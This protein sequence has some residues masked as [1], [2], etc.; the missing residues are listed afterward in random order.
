[1]EGILIT[2]VEETLFLQLALIWKTPK[3]RTYTS[4]YDDGI[5]W[6]LIDEGYLPKLGEKYPMSIGVCQ[7]NHPKWA[8]GQFP[9]G[10]D[11]IGIGFM[12]IL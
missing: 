5:N 6:E 4:R 12:G 2:R 7:T 3:W 11:K 9:Y 8:V 10:K 1:M